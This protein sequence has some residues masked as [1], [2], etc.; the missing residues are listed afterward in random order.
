MLSPMLHGA[1]ASPQQKTW[2]RAAGQP[3]VNRWSALSYSLKHVP[4]SIGCSCVGE[5]WVRRLWNHTG[6]GLMPALTPSSGRAW[7][8]HSALPEPRCSHLRGAGRQSRMSKLYGHCHWKENVSIKSQTYWDTVSD[9]FGGWGGGLVLTH[10]S[11]GPHLP[12]D[13]IYVSE[14]RI[15]VCVTLSNSSY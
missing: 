8:S 15:I 4:I 6:W 5:Q 2:Q 3:V 7:M 13:T 14:T 1:H 12:R 11:F 9:V 10:E